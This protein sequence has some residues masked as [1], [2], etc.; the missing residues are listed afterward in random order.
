SGRS[1]GRR[2]TAPS[3]S[4][5]STPLLA[6]A[7]TA[8]DQPVGFLVLAA[9]AL[10]E[11][12]HAPRGDRMAAALRL[13]LA[14]AVRVVDGVHRRATHGRALA[15]PTAPACLPAGLVLVV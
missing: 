4:I 12:G 5:C 15:Q 10:A 2:R 1:A 3:C 7:A 11:R 13:P 8:D 14:A 6:A 9:R